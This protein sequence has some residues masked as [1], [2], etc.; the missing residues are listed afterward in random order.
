MLPVGLDH[1]AIWIDRV[2]DLA[3]IRTR[4]R[5]TPSMMLPNK[6]EDWPHVFE[7]HLNAGDLDAVMALYEPGPV[8]S[9]SPAK[10][11][12]AMTGFARC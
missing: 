1:F 7:Q 2:L 9:P 5:M 6:P 3:D 12:L 11:W 10:R 8:S 4:R